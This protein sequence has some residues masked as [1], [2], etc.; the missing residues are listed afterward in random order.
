MMKSAFFSAT[1]VLAALAAIVAVAT[2]G[3][4][5]Q[6]PYKPQQPAQPQPKAQQQVPEGERKA[7]EKIQTAPDIET[8]MKAAGEFVK[9]FPK[10][11]LRAQVVGHLGSQVTKTQDPAQQIAQL[12]SLAVMFD[13]PSESQI[14][15]PALIEAYIKAQRVDDAFTAA[16][17]LLEKN[18][19]DVSTLLRMAILSTEQIKVGNT[20][21]IQTGQQYAAKAVGLIEDDKKPETLSAEQ[22]SEYKTRWLP[23]LYYLL[24]FTSYY[25]NNKPG[26]VE[27]LEKA[28]TLKSE[29]PMTYV[30]LGVIMNE[31]YETLAKKFQSMSGGPLKEETLKQAQAKMDEVIDQFARAVA[32]SEGQ[33]VYKKL[34]DQILPSLE[35]YYKYRHNNSTTGLRELIDKYKKP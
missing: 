21:Y 12:E 16:T 6:D 34:Y 19:N 5:Q 18:P 22:W 35:N 26:A 27:H 14:I 17:K 8:K 4:A 11:T 31:E 9:K 32:L 7:V 23:H 2:V 3:L 25:S 28:V 33:D 10:S 24:G 13:Q 29:D 30:L 1:R 15:Y 20:K